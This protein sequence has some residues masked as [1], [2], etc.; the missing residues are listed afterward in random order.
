MGSP[1]LLFFFLV[2]DGELISFQTQ[3]LDVYDLT[4]TA[5]EGCCIH[6]YKGAI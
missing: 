2:S 1:G 4:G 3:T 6:G 5:F